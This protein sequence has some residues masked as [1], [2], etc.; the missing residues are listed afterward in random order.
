[1]KHLFGR[2]NV[3]IFTPIVI[4]SL[5]GSWIGIYFIDREMTGHIKNEVLNDIE[6]V[7]SKLYHLVKSNFTTLFYSYGTSP[8]AYEKYARLSKNE[9]I[10]ELR[11]TMKNSTH[12][13]CYIKTPEGVIPIRGEAMPAAEYSRMEQSGGSFVTGEGEAFFFAST[14]F[15]PWGWEIMTLRDKASYA[16]IVRNNS[17]M[18]I[19]T[20]FLIS[21]VTI[22][23]LIIVIRQIINRPLDVVLDH[24]KR[25]RIGDYRP[26]ELRSSYEINKLVRNLNNMSTKIAAREE[27]EKREHQ[28]IKQILDAQS[29]IVLLADSRRLVD[30]NNRFFEFFEGCNTL[31]DFLKEHGCLGNLFEVV[32]SPGYLYNTI[33]G[34][35]WIA[36]LEEH[37]GE[38]FKVEINKNGSRTVFQVLADRLV[39]NGEAMNIIV[40]TDITV[41]ENYRIELERQVA[42]EVAKNREKEIKLMEQSKRASMAELLIAI[43]H[44]WRQPLTALSLAIQEIRDA[45]EYGEMDEAYIATVEKN[46]LGTINKM[47]ETIN[48][49]SMLFKKEHG[50]AVF[51][52]VP[53]TEEIA[54]TLL[55]GLESIACHC[56]HDTAPLL[57]TGNDAEYK[58]IILSILN[59]AKDAILER[60]DEGRI[61]KGA[62]EVRLSTENGNVRITIED[63]GGGIDAAQQEKIFEPYFSTKEEGKGVGL[64]LFFAKNLVENSFK[65]RI[66]VD[67]SGEG[68][69]F[70]VVLPAATEEEV[71]RGAL[72]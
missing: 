2:I 15:L 51:D 47:S 26:L 58:E 4:I 52:I 7:N 61:S 55:G 16:K 71:Q 37:P 6:T 43:S 40:L 5:L 44:H 42:A 62:V 66:E 34:K 19:A 50:T 33:G 67:N 31:E 17:W 3:R 57:I 68:A 13:L 10:N 53:I 69:R 35:G 20:I 12:Y 21:I 11:E 1:M 46:A 32:D 45:Y 63:N 72:S 30:V 48:S 60:I 23:V 27:E 54:S 8:E 9:T 29:S 24:L 28:R 41:Y 39:I 70:I 36:Y 59:N 49:F 64:G 38:H 22:G 56:H 65:G 18:V 14:P 25:I